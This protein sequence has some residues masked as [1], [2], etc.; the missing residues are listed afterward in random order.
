M[1]SLLEDI[2]VLE[3]APANTHEEKK[4]YKEK[5][6]EIRRKITDLMKSA[7][8]L[9]NSLVEE[10]NKP[11]P[12]STVCFHFISIGSNTDITKKGSSR[13]Q[14]TIDD[15]STGGPT[16]ESSRSIARFRKSAGDCKTRSKKHQNYGKAIG[17]YAKSPRARRR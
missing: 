2:G 13:C 10:M 9:K 14:H 5:S 16:R 3:S 12:D 17:G 15:K 4:A 7:T 11:K 1:W 6:A 8:E